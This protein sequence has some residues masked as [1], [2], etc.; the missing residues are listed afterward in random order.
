MDVRRAVKTIE[1]EPITVGEKE[2]VPMARVISVFPGRGGS[3][4]RVK[5][6]AV[7]EITPQG[8]R[9]IP[10]H[11]VTMRALMAIFLAGL[12]L[13]FIVVR[14]VARLRPEQ[15]PGTST[16]GENRVGL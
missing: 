16:T 5:P 7:L 8:E 2:I 3:F 4:V 11:D 1:G 15:V 13:P 9:C 6:V 14:L 10:I 12:I